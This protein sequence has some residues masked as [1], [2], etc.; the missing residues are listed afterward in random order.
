MLVFKT[1]KMFTKNKKKTKCGKRIYKKKYFTVVY[2]NDIKIGMITK[3]SIS[4]GTSKL[5]EPIKPEDCLGYNKE[6]QEFFKA[7]PPIPV[8]DTTKYEVSEQDDMVKVKLGTV[9][10]GGIRLYNTDDH[11]NL[12]RVTKEVL[13]EIQNVSISSKYMFDTRLTEEVKREIQNS[14]PANIN[15]LNIEP[16]PFREAG[17][18]K[19][20]LIKNIEDVD[21]KDVIESDYINIWTRRPII[22]LD[23]DD[24]IYD[25]M[26][27][28]IQF[29]EE[30]Y[31]V[32][33]VHLEITD[34]YYLYNNYPRIAEEL[35]N[36]PENYITSEL[37]DGALE[38]YKELVELVGEDRIQ[39]VTSS[40]ENV[41][42][43]KDRMIKERFGINC[44][45][46]H[47][48]F[49]KFKKHHFTK[50]TFLIEDCVGNVRDH[51]IHNQNHGIIFNHMNLK[52]IKKECDAEGFTHTTTYGELIEYVKRYLSSMGII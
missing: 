4:R 5:I 16:L 32:K 9:L 46:I 49:G 35:W 22:S 28:N 33:D 45:I 25:L 6:L 14:Y 41:I 1:H 24:V 15:P 7:N 50:N 48:I 2:Q 11:G 39:I 37:I 27:K 13:E 3:V 23:L 43:L 31:G 36:H 51:Y 42:P 18:S 17:K 12:V 21:N 29:V 30:V 26:K 52:Y 44:K 20:W 10:K 47:S 8:K 40:M 38:F 34:Y 19:D